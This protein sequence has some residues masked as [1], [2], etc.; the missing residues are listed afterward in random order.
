MKKE[1]KHHT[2]EEKVSILRRQRRQQAREELGR[3]DCL[4]LRDVLN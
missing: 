2:P 3:V 4:P 1:H